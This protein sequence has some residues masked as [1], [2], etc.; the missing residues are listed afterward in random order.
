MNKK[1]LI[2]S[3]SAKCG[4][5]QF[6]VSM[7]FTAIAETIQESL[8]KEESVILIGYGTFSVK[9]R[10]AHKGFN[11]ATREAIQIPACK[12]VRFKASVKKR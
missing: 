1:E 5:P 6:F 12:V 3:A 11:P 2:Q 8:A 7:A 4:M 9:E 10:K